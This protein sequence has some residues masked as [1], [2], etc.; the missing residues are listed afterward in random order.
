MRQISACLLTACLSSILTLWWHDAATLAPADAQDANGPR[1]PGNQPPRDALVPDGLLPDELVS[2]AIYENT[3]RSVVHITSRGLRADNF[4]F[5]EIEEGTGSGSVVDRNGHILTNYHVIENAREITVGLFDGSSWPATLVGADPVC[6]IAVL[7]ID[8]PAEVLYPVT[9][10]DSSRLKVGMR[11]FA[12]G[13]PFGLE[14]T[15][16][17]GIISSLNRSLPFRGTRSVRSIIQIDASVNPGS[18]GGPLLDSR[19]HLIGMTTAIASKTG[20]SAGVGFAIPSN[21]IRR[22]VPQLIR[23]GKVI[24]PETGIA[25]VFQTEKGLLV[26]NLTSK[27]PA[28]RAGLRGPQ[29]V[30]QRRGPFVIERVDRKAADLIVGVDG[31]KV[32]SADDLLDYIDEKR[33]GETIVLEVIRDGK[34]VQVSLLLGG[35]SIE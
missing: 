12:I 18:S 23:F 1:F 10:G 14:R 35:E 8:A 30:R 3:N 5:V 19:G 9:L 4:I 28:E 31:R 17:T 15:M 22:V 29:T 13:N 27:G 26:A 25:K 2:I 24:R 21:L 16:A 11:V 6:D 7:K 20:Q 33:A 32:E 34:P